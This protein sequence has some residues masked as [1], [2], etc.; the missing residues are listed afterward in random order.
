MAE[1][2]G[3]EELLAAATRL[4]QLLAHQRLRIKLQGLR[5]N[6]LTHDR[7]RVKLLRDNHGLR[8]DLLLDYNA[9]ANYLLARSRR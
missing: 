7:L 3:G 5:D 2:L 8:H 1:L 6:L 9:L 4:Y